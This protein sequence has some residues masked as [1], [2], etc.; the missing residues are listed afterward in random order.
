[1]N[2]KECQ[3]GLKDND[4]DID[5]EKNVH[6]HL[7]SIN[8]HLTHEED[9]DIINKRGSILL[10]G[11]PPQNT[12]YALFKRLMRMEVYSSS[13]NPDNYIS[14]SSQRNNDFIE[15][16]SKLKQYDINQQNDFFNVKF[17][18]NN[19]SSQGKLQ[20][21]CSTNLSPLASNHVRNPS[22]QN[23][24]YNSKIQEYSKRGKANN[25]VKLQPTNNSDN[26]STDQKYC[27]KDPI[28]MI[29]PNCSYNIRT[30]VDLESHY[31]QNPLLFI[32][33][34]TLFILLS[35]AIIVLITLLSLCFC[36][37]P[38]QNFMKFY[39]N[40]RGLVKEINIYHSCAKCKN[41]VGR[42]IIQQ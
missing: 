11:P 40:V 16:N 9:L 18:N 10:N 13:E 31:T 26:Y 32:I 2:Q 22:Q 5:L 12:H 28:E 35:P 6:V 17:E 24:M 14:E 33:K 23:L 15:T 42:G 39:Q 4:D 29:C 34:M 8:E 38:L 3:F 7:N 36:S 27:T 21:Y 20:N 30:Y 25:R 1:M 19:C 41:I 37:N